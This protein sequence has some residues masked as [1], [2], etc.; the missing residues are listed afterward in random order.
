LECEFYKVKKR[1]GFYVVGEGSC[2][3]LVP[4]GAKNRDPKFSFS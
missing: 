2:G 1:A 4:S 3:D